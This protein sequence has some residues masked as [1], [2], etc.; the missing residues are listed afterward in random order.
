MN[1][2]EQRQERLSNLKKGIS[3]LNIRINNVEIE[4]RMLAIDLELAKQLQTL[5]KYK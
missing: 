3:E 4:A 2:I 5:K 1:T